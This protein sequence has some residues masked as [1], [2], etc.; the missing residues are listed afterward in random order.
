MADNAA[1]PELPPGWDADHSGISIFV[2]VFC[3]FVSTVMV[4]LRVY[5]RRVIINQMGIDDWAAI[6]TLLLVYG[7]GITI[8]ITTQYGLGKHIYAIDP[9]L[10]PGYLKC[11]WV[12]IVLY[13]AGLLAAKLTL[14]FQYYRIMA[15]QHMRKIYIAA[16]VIVTAWGL[17][18]LLIGLLM[19]RPIQGFWDASVEAKCIPNYPQFYINAAGN[20]ATDIAVFLLPLPV[21]KH[22]NLPRTQRL[23]LFGIFSLG[24]FTVAISVI[25]IKYLKVAED[26][27]WENVESSGWSLG[28]LTSALTCAC[29]PT[30]RPLVSRFI[31]ALATAPQRSTMGYKKSTNNIDLE[32]RHTHRKNTSVGGS[33]DDKNGDRYNVHLTESKAETDDET[34]DVYQTKS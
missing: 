26:M 1:A 16:I 31:P 19:C 13:C 2:V 15:V 30:L 3:L 34:E 6:V 28:E 11:F 7:D 29:L 17:S 4:G 12:S 23:I 8:A 33:V 32:S 21:I 24:F 14:L 10:I 5:T 22:L 9:T 18:Q 27:T 25:R 20:I